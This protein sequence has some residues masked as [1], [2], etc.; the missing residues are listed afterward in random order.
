M[1]IFESSENWQKIMVK[2]SEL[3]AVLDAEWFW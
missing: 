1:W 2:Y 3:K